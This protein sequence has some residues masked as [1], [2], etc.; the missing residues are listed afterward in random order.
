MN[1]LHGT[2]GQPST[3]EGLVPS[4]NGYGYVAPSE[5]PTAHPAGFS[6]PLRLLI[7]RHRHL[8][9]LLSR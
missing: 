8:L 4:P 3:T 9:R 7:S 6:T 1:P 5:A 2:T